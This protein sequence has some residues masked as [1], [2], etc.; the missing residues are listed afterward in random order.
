VIDEWVAVGRAR[1]RQAVTR[2]YTGTMHQRK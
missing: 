2:P 1:A